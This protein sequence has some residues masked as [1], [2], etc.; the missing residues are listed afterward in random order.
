[1][2]C[3]YDLSFFLKVK[4]NYNYLR[5]F[6]GFKENIKLKIICEYGHRSAKFDTLLYY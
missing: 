1:M 3:E 6:S 4:E 5:F 2:L